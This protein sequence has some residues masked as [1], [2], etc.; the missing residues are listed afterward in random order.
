ML[1]SLQVILT[2]FFFFFLLFQKHGSVGR[3]ETQHFVGMALFVLRCSHLSIS[4]SIST[5][6]TNMFV[7]LVLMLV[8]MRL[9]LCLCASENSIRQI[10]GFLLIFLFILLTLMSRVFSLV[11]LMLRLCASE[12]H[13]QLYECDDLDTSFLRPLRKII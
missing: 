13:S 7:F 11:T 4:I 8:L 9:C 5:R 10:G 2:F 12:N 6:K 1:A 3:W